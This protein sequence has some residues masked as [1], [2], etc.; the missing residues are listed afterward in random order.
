MAD[1]GAVELTGRPYLKGHG[2]EN[3]FVLLPDLDA[4]LRLTPEA[5]R[6]LCD[7]RQGLGA[8]GVLRVVPSA[9]HPESAPHAEH[10]AW[11]M[12]HHNADG[13]TAEM[14]GNGVRLFGRYL[15]RA[16]LAEPGRLPVVTRGGVKVLDVAPG[17]GPVTVDMGPAEVGGTV[18]VDGASAQYVSMGNPHGRRPG[19]LGGGAGGAP[20]RRLDLNVGTSRT[21]AHPRADARARAR[22][23]RDPLLRHRCVRRGRRDVAAH[24]SRR[25]TAFDVDVPGGRLSITWQEDG[26]VLMT[27]PAVLVASG[28]LD[29]G[30]LA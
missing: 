14:C 3:D 21:S 6:R 8:D 2:T 12:D 30:L 15:V 26:R 23:R 5:V 10:A 17:D 24:R 29:E 4:T 25:G 16:G 19:G 27:G 1:R 7:R 13:T 9:L 11:F 28:V 20:P 18:E 22:R